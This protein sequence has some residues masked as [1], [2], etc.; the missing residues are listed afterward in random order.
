MAEGSWAIG[1]LK[2]YDMPRHLLMDSN[3]TSRTISATSD[4]LSLDC[5]YPLLDHPSDAKR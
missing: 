3:G 1:T 2:I 5:M 4:T